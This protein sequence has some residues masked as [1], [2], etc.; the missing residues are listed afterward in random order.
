MTDTCTTASL[1][2]DPQVCVC[3]CVSVVRLHLWIVL[4][5]PE[6]TE[7]FVFWTQQPMFAVKPNGTGRIEQIN[8]TCPYTGH[9]MWHDEK[10]TNSSEKAKEREGRKKRGEKKG[11]INNTYKCTGGSFVKTVNLKAFQLIVN[12]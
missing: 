12:S 8:K 5:G 10:A 4:P 3:V 11:T 1:V 9:I 2:K 6:E 7:P